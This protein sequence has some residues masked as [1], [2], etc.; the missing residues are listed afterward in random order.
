M[1]GISRQRRATGVFWVIVGSFGFRLNQ[2]GTRINGTKMEPLLSERV[3]IT[4]ATGKLLDRLTAAPRWTLLALA[5]L[6]I[7]VV[8]WLDWRLGDD[9][10][11]GAFYVFPVLILSGILSRWQLISVAVLCVLLR[12]LFNPSPTFASLVLEGGF[13]LLAYALIGLFASDVIRHRLE[14]MENLTEIR[15]QQSLRAAAEEQLRVLAESSPAAIFTLNENAEILS[16]NRA[17]RELLGLDASV[18]LIGR[19]IESNLPVLAEALKLDTRQERFRTV[20]QVQGQRFDGTPFVAQACFSSYREQSGGV[21][22]AAIAFDSTEDTRDREEQN[23]QQILQSNL[24]IAGAVAHEVRNVCGAMS[25][26][27]SNLNRVEGIGGNRDY[28]AIGDLIAGLGKLAHLEL[29]G[30]KEQQRHTA[31]LRDVLN[32]LRILIEPVWE[33]AGAQIKWPQL[34]QPVLAAADSFTLLQAFLNITNNSLSAVSGRKDKTLRISAEIRGQLAEVVFWDSGAGV[35]DPD[36][37]FQPF[38]TG[39][40]NVGLGLYISRALLRKYG[41][42]VRYDGVVTPGTCFAVEVPL[43]G[44][45]NAYSANRNN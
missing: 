43:H 1:Y 23:Q 39:F 34:P 24:L 11:L 4:G 2:M 17:T 15:H 12:E 25:V 29:Q 7:L 37:L 14:I 41:G 10:S 8:A 38:R 33:D 21:R 35:A 44:V 18:P 40:G 6:S 22:L 20:A 9:V 31:E 36:S 16:A 19:S 32:Q 28:Q 42:D 30:E 3:L 5:G 27:H 26:L 13:G 45:G